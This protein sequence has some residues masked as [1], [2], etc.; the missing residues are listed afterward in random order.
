M[1]R[2]LLGLPPKET[3]KLEVQ[4]GLIEAQVEIAR[5]VVGEITGVKEKLV[6][7][8][9]GALHKLREAKNESEPGEVS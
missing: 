6:A 7:R 1:L 5:E 8:A 4:A 3:K 2:T 9:N